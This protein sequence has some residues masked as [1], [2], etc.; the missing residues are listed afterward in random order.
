MRALFATV[1]TVE[2]WDV[3]WKYGLTGHTCSPYTLLW[4]CELTGSWRS[5][6]V[7]QG[8]GLKS[9][10]SVS[11]GGGIRGPGVSN[12][13]LETRRVPVQANK[14]NRKASTEDMD[15]LWDLVIPE[16]CVLLSWEKQCLVKDFS[17]SERRIY[18]GAG[19]VRGFGCSTAG[20]GG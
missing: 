12:L 16:L 18:Q 9:D 11:A 6:S 4:L 19:P 15:A 20:R 14:L 13:V 3:T 1:P 8:A 17:L 2:L 7:T 5:T 10:P